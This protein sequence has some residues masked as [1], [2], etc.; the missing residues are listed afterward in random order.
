MG[1]LVVEEVAISPRNIDFELANIINKCSEEDFQRALQQLDKDG[2][3]DA[4]KMTNKSAL[5]QAYN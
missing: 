4:S 2:V 5:K 1:N 3:F